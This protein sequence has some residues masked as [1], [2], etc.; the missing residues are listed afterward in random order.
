M[1][2]FYLLALCLSMSPSSLSYPHRLHHDA[3]DGDDN[4]CNGEDG[5]DDYDDYDYADDDSDASKDK[6]DS[7]LITS[8]AIIIISR[9]I[10]FII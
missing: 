2:Q 5:D 10:L 3:D 8:L 4:D 6:D 9:S 1:V 7:F